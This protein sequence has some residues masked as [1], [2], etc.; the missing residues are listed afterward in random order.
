M[1]EPLNNVINEKFPKLKIKNCKECLECY[2]GSASKYK[3]Q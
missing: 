3:K 2:I 1:Q